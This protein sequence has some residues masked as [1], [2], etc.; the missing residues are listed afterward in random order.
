MRR[1]KI[2]GDDHSNTPAVVMAGIATETLEE[3]LQPHLGRSIE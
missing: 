2:S 3:E 1:V